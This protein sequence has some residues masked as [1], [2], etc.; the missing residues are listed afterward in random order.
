MINIQIQIMTLGGQAQ[1][2][3][4]TT[5]SQ[6]QKPLWET[7]SNEMPS[8]QHSRYTDYAMGWVICALNLNREKKISLLSDV[9]TSLVAHLASYTRDIGGKGTSP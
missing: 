6:S 9:L 4:T 5:H 8:R 1:Q 2:Q 7:S 3:S